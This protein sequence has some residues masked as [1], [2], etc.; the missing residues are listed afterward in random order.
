MVSHVI[1]TDS[2]AVTVHG[3]SGTIALT[4]PFELDCY[5]VDVGA[6]NYK[7]TVLVV[8]GNAFQLLPYT[9]RLMDMHAPLLAFAFLLGLIC[10]R[11]R[12]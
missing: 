1:V 4:G 10:A 8:S 9:P 7:G 6:T 2:S 3:A 12:L 5:S 11:F